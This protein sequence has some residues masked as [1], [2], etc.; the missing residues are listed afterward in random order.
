MSLGGAKPQPGTHHPKGPTGSL[1]CSSHLAA[2][3]DM[4]TSS[5]SG[6]GSF[7]DRDSGWLQGAGRHLVLIRPEAP[8]LLPACLS[9]LTQTPHPQMPG[10]PA[11]A[12]IPT[13]CSHPGG[14][15]RQLPL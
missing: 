12:Q 6:G 7:R 4:S 10:L 15:T 2:C 9:S 3:P 13:Q 11:T 1:L 8:G 5:P 14:P